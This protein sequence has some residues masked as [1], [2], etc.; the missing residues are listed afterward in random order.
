MSAGSTIGS[1]T[2]FQGTGFSD[3]WRYTDAQSA[4]QDEQHP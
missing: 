3:Q 2:Q 4:A 1:M